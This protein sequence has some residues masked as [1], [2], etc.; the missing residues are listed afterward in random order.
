[1]QKTNY[2]ER[3]RLGYRI[4]QLREG[5]DLSQTDLAKKANVIQAQV[6]QIERGQI[7]ASLDVLQRIASALGCTID[8]VKL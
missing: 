2:P 1:M 3:E 6:S 8:F 7:S 4:K 5:N